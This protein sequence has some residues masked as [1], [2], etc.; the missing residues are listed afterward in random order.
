MNGAYRSPD[1]VRRT[2]HSGF[3]TKKVFSP[4]RMLTKA[5]R[6]V[7][8]RQIIFETA[9]W[10]PP[11]TVTVRTNVYGWGHDIAGRF[12]HGRW[13]FTLPG[14]DFPAGF[15]M[16]LI[17][18]DKFWMVGGDVWI[19]KRE[20]DH[21]F[22]DGAA[23]FAYQIQFKT[24]R[25]KPNNLITLRNDVDGWARDIY[26]TFRG[27]SWIFL[28][29][30]AY[31]PDNFQAKLVAERSV[32]M[33]GAN[34]ALTSSAPYVTLDDQTADFAAAPNAF[35]HGY[36]N[37]LPLDT[38]MEPLTL[39]SVG[40][41][42]EEFD[43]LIIGSGTGGGT[44]ADALSN[45]G[46]K[47]LVLEAG[48]IRYPLHFN[49]LSRSE[50]DI[51]GRDQLGHYN[52]RGNPY[53]TMGVHFN[54]GGR[55][56][57]W[58]GVIP[59]MQPWEFRNVWPTVVCDYL[60]N[61]PPSGLSGYDRAEDLMNKQKTLG[62]F[63]ES[64]CTFLNMQLAG[65]FMASE[66]PRSMDQPD[67]NDAGVLQNVVRRTTGGFST[68]D[69]LLDSLGFSDSAGRNNIRVNLQHLATSIET[70]GR[71]AT[72]VVCQDLAGNVER[73]YEA[74]I[75]VL[76]CGSLESPKLALNSG[77]VDPNGK[78]GIGLTDHPAYFYVNHH[79]LPTTGPLAWLG[80]PGGHAKI[81]VRP[82]ESD[83]NNHA[84][85]IEMLINSKYWDARHADDVLWRHLVDNGQPSRVEVKFIFSSP[86]MDS[87]KIVAHGAG[88]KT[89]VY[90]AENKSADAYKQEMVV[91]R[92]QVLGALGVTGLS[93]S[94]V[95]D[96]WSEGIYGTVNHAGGTLRMSDDGSGVL[97]ENLK[98]LAY[99][100]LYCC[101]VSAFPS[102][103]AANPSLT[104]AALAL[105]LADTLAAAL[106]SGHAP[107]HAETV[108]AG[109]A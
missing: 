4:E 34:L 96:E 73:R 48:G 3:I 13:T 23:W 36:D 87:N 31:Y 52:N 33:N 54:L 25:W 44:L 102:I 85:Y 56:V 55:S 72:A 64:V 89:D 6:G 63:A 9:L 28:L 74:K 84:Y 32:Y 69:L 37:F 65:S 21:W 82:V 8:D 79:E 107:G 97:D 47:V 41:E 80:D 49:E 40:R 101:D 27:D 86:L 19:D 66:L 16:K 12:A 106:Q 45:Q 83:L 91:A 78:I 95:A 90:V 35:V 92:N 99:D 100:N 68:T 60:L 46:V 7:I 24:N 98:F 81:I 71:E 15:H 26:G 109:V 11:A 57:Y 38:P 5:D 59:R 108:G 14:A 67:I 39:R 93:T 61:A 30:R 105:R 43:V 53:F 94:W 22:N 70:S 17:L 75:V 18:D 1:E 88:Q 20:M 10:Q 76:A 50:V 42:D 104:L 2:Y 62:P 77:L 58:S 29:D 51:E 103:P